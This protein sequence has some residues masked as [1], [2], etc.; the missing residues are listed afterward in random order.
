MKPATKKRLE[1]MWYTLSTIFLILAFVYSFISF[2][3]GDM[4]CDLDRLITSG[5][6]V[7]WMALAL[8][9]LKLSKEPM[10]NQNI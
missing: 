2:T 9:F 4:L 1:K 7:V 5:L 10:G 3:E 6:A 8:I